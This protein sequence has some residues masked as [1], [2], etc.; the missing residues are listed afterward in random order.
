MNIQCITMPVIQNLR[1]TALWQK[2]LQ[3][4]ACTLI[5]LSIYL[6]IYFFRPISPCCLFQ[7]YEE[8]TS[9]CDTEELTVEQVNQLKYLDYC[10]NEAMRLYPQGFRYCAQPLLLYNCNLLFPLG[11]ANPWYDT[12]TRFSQN[13][14]GCP[15]FSQEYS[16]L[17]G[18]TQSMIAYKILTG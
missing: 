16:K 7:L 2:E 18:D 8:I 10:I 15:T 9:V 17:I 5:S 12:Y 6:S 3:S 13:L 4:W 14:I 11:I 1:S